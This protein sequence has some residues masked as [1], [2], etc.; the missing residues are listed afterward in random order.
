MAWDFVS[1]FLYAF[2]DWHRLKLTSRAN[3]YSKVLVS[4]YI[5]CP[6]CYMLCC[7]VLDAPPPRTYPLYRRADALLPART[8]PH[9]IRHTLSHTLSL[10]P[11]STH[12][13]PAASCWG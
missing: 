6:T 13:S 3:K 12:H 11:I 1:V 5:L 10:S 2:V 8:H 9:P 4:L 7:W